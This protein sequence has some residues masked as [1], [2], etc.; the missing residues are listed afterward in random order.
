MVDGLQG[1]Y[2][3]FFARRRFE[4]WNRFVLGLGLR[5]LGVLNYE[6]PAVSGEEFLVNDLLPGWLGREP[7]IFDVGAHHGEYSRLLAKRFPGAHIH[8]FEPNPSSRISFDAPGPAVQL[9]PIGLGAKQE[10]LTLFDRAEDAGSSHASLYSSVISELHHAQSET[11]EVTITTIDQVCLDLGLEAIDFL[12]IDVEG[13]ELAVF[14]GAKR[15]LDAG[16]IHLVQFE[17]NEMNVVSRTF[18]RDFKLL[19]PDHV[20]Y[21]LLPRGLLPLGDVPVSTELFAFQNILAV[22]R[23]WPVP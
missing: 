12:K 10:V 20:L 14:A 23:G 19:L 6:D 17:F 16:A 22:P 18:L 13:H 3:Y 7:T 1:L 5:G 9:H 2:R 15:L 8:A 21:R 11:V 4:K